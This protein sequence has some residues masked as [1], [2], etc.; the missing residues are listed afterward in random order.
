[1][2]FRSAKPL[3][4][5]ESWTRVVGGIVEHA[6]VPGF[7]GNVAD[8]YDAADTE[9][10][11]WREFVGEWWVRFAGEKQTTSTLYPIAEELG[12]FDLGK[13]QDKARRTMFGMLLGKQRDRV[14]GDYRV[15]SG[16]KNH[17]AR[18]WQLVQGN[19]GN[20]GEPFTT[21]PMRESKNNCSIYSG[22]DEYQK[23]RL[24]SPGSPFVQDDS[25]EVGEWTR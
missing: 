10:V 2:L 8:F 25:S 19:Q 23:V 16:G 13:G 22:G 6:G 14:I 11:A 17:G 24:G 1:M 3:G 15:S 5:F 20:L 9:G 7:L 12:C 18:L 4:S 21:T